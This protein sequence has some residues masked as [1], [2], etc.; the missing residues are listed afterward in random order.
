[1]KVSD[2]KLLAI[3]GH[4][5]GQSAANPKFLAELKALLQNQLD[6]P[7]ECL[8][9]VRL[10]DKRVSP[11]AGFILCAEVPAGGTVRSVELHFSHG[12]TFN[13]LK[14]ETRPLAPLDL[15]ANG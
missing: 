14:N 4:A 9:E 2:G 1:M 13:Y 6:I 7:R 3:C 5:Y 8:T 15:G 11:P 12:L 10:A